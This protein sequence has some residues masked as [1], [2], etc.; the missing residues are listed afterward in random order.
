M[1]A[2]THVAA[3]STVTDVSCGGPDPKSK[4]T[5]AV[6]PEKGGEEAL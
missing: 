3:T 6:F 1:D 4:S 2:V 5:V